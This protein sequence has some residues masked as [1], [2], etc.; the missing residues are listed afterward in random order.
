MLVIYQIPSAEFSALEALY[1]STHGEGWNWLTNYGVYGYPWQFNTSVSPNPTQQNPCSTSRPWQGVTCSNNCHNIQC[2]ITG[3]TLSNYGLRGTLPNALGELS[4]LT[5]MTI[6]DNPLLQGV[7]PESLTNSISTLRTLSLDN[8]GLSGKLPNSYYA[9][10]NSLTTLT[11]SGNGLTSSLPTN[12]TTSLLALQVLDLSSNMLTGSLSSTIGD[13][14][15]LLEFD[16]ASNMI[17]GLLPATMS[18]MTKLQ[19]LLVHDNMLTGEIPVQLFSNFPFLLQLEIDD[20]Q[21]TGNSFLLSS[22]LTSLTR[23]QLVYY[24]SNFFSGSLPA[25][26][27]NMKTLGQWTGNNNLVTGSIPVNVTSLKRMTRFWMEYNFLSHTLPSAMGLLSALTY[28]DLGN[29]ILSGTLPDSLCQLTSIQ[30]LYLDNN[31]FHGPLPQQIG[32]LQAMLQFS[33]AFNSLSQSLPTTF[34]H[35]QGLRIAYLYDNSFSGTLSPAIGNMTALTSLEINDNFV[36]GTIPPTITSLSNLRYLFLYNNSLTG[37][38]PS[39]GYDQ[40]T[41]LWDFFVE[42]NYLSGTVPESL[43][44][45]PRVQVLLINQNLFSGTISE[46]IGLLPSSLRTLQFDNNYF[47]GTIP[48]NLTTLTSLISLLIGETLVT[49]T[50]PQDIGNLVGLRELKLYNNHL[51]GSLPD[52]LYNCVQLTTLSL[53]GNELTGTISKEID[54]LLHIQY[55]GLYDNH[56]SGTIPDSLCNTWKVA[57]QMY[58]LS[59]HFTGTIPACY[60]QLR[61]LQQ[62]EFTANHL[63]GTIPQEIFQLP[64]LQIFYGAINFFTGTLSSNI[65]SMTLLSELNFA[66]NML[67]GTLPA[68]ISTLPVVGYIYLNYNEF[69]GE[70]PKEWFTMPSVQMLYLFHNQLTGNITAPSTV[71]TTTITTSTVTSPL[72]GICTMKLLQQLDLHGN[73]I[74]GTIP[75]CLI[76]PLPYTPSSASADGAVVMTSNK[77]KYLYLYQNHFSGN[78]SIMPTSSISISTNRSSSSSNLQEVLLNDNMLSSALHP[79]IVNAWTKVQLLNLSNNFFTS[80]LPLS[81][82][83]LTALEVVDLSSNTFSGSLSNLFTQACALKILFL[84]Y[85]SFDG[86]LTLLFGTA[87]DDHENPSQY[88]QESLVNLDISGNQL[89][90][91]LPREIFLLSNL[92]TFAAAKNCITGSIP[93]DTICL[94][95]KLQSL[96]LDGLH[97]ADSCQVP[98]LPRRIAALLNTKSYTLKSPI[99]GSIPLCVFTNI[100]TLQTLHLSG[101]AIDG[102]IPN[103]ASSQA[104]SISPSLKDL[105]LSHNN[106][107]GSIPIE[108]QRHAWTSLDLSFNKI[109]GSLTNVYPNY[110]YQTDSSNG[111]NNSSSAVN[112]TTLKLEVNRLSGFVPPSLYSMRSINILKGNVFDCRNE[113]QAEDELPKHDSETNSYRCGSSAVNDPLYAW[114]V[115]IVLGLGVVL[116]LVTSLRTKSNG[117]GGFCFSDL[118]QILQSLAANSSIDDAGSISLFKN[119]VLWWNTSTTSTELNGGETSAYMVS[120]SE[121]MK[122][123]RTM[124]QNW[125]LVVLI[126][127]LPLDVIFSA[128]Y[129]TLQFPY[130][131]VVSLAYKHGVVPAITFLV[132]LTM[133]IVWVESHIKSFIRHHFQVTAGNNEAEKK[134]REKLFAKRRRRKKKDHEQDDGKDL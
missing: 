66:F 84:Q 49:G 102:I 5:T 59:N 108:I 21:F 40:M 85:N 61:T 19:Q 124:C 62:L 98:V 79:S 114:I 74:T 94:S 93:F 80:S 104:A 91:T 27:S 18:S 123:L 37:T 110:I 36:R 118:Q 9:V 38:L 82:Q 89:Q 22:G 132:I 86:P 69:E 76:V 6:T 41:S 2:H 95:K 83:N 109:G 45:L 97:T 113:L 72:E 43:F 78:F 34:Y 112:S 51:T 115:V 65:S 14:K 117:K 52:S 103:F 56:F 15:L 4:K 48:K 90:G 96:A 67:T 24:D 92:S 70:V 44:L 130:V 46:S 71:T 105:S 81:F 129:S 107:K 28:L 125:T 106:L 20:N 32:N 42:Q 16:I 127:L 39:S 25:T 30:N 63:T 10:S 87:S 101:N 68:S 120:F 131:W 121:A 50:I 47:R 23:V 54:R 64:L 122:G 55:L 126:I 73:Y 17:T 1:N 7:I 133:I 29:N 100:S 11:L 88:C 111:T 35:L 3:L 26:I 60:A 57:T 99:T 119:V 31:R 33:V 13:L 8:N 134:E 75:S 128:Y 58:F 53:Y 77:L 116:G 12:L